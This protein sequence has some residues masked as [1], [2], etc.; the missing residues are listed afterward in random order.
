[1]SLRRSRSVD[2]RAPT[3]GQ[4]QQHQEDEPVI[5][6]VRT[7]PPLR[8]D[9][10]RRTSNRDYARVCR[11]R[12]RARLEHLKSEVARLQAV[13]GGGTPS[14]CAGCAEGA[15]ALLQTQTELAASRAAVL[16]LHER[17]VAWLP[18]LDRHLERCGG[19]CGDERHECVG[20]S[21]PQRSNTASPALVSSPHSPHDMSS[22]LGVTLDLQGALHPH[23]TDPPLSLR[24]RPTVDEFNVGA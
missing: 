16:A 21:M 10:K 8:P 23:S 6:S 11:K 1:M 15:D 20:A 18:R 12:K 22:E 9:L 4:A 2:V 14:P 5:K 7:P 17:F 19:S 13:V 24:G 3:E